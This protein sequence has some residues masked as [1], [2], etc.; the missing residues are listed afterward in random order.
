MVVGDARLTL[1]AAPDRYDLIVLDAFSSDSIPVHLLTREALHMYM[2]KLAPGGILA[3]HVS[4]RFLDIVPAVAATVA[5]LPGA[6][7]FHSYPPAAA[8]EPDATRSQV[9]F[10]TRDADAAAAVAKAWPSEKPLAGDPALAWT[11]DYSDV[12]S[13]LIRGLWRS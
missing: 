2:D 6:A 7:A 8:P 4:N 11:D 3:L 13:A 10:V 12:L 1:E 5:T 9:V